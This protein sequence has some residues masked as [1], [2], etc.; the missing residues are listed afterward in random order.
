MSEVTCGG[1]SPTKCEVAA[2]VVG[3]MVTEDQHET[4]GKVAQAMVKARKAVDAAALADES[5]PL[6]A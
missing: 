3:A 5:T 2:A 4:V 1:L 6:E